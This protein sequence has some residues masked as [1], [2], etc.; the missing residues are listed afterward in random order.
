MVGA[1]LGLP[2]AVRW[3]QIPVYQAK[4]RENR[5]ILGLVFPTTLGGNYATLL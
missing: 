5:H 1:A 2:K 3:G 4:Y